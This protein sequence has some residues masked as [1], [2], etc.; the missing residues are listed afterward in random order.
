MTLKDFIDHLK[1][2]EKLEVTMMSQGVAMIYSFFMGK[3]RI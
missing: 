3:G 2:K 1:E